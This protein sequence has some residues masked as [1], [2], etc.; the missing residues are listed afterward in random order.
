MRPM[1]TVSP[2][3][4]SGPS[5]DQLA[6]EL[7]HFAHQCVGPASAEVLSDPVVQVRLLSMIRNGTELRDAALGELHRRLATAPRVA[8]EFLAHFLSDLSRR[9]HRMRPVEYQRL[10]DTGDLVQSV[11]ADLWPDIQEVSF[12][13]RGQ[14]LSYLSKRL[15]WKSQD[16]ARALRTDRRGE[17][18]RIDWALDEIDSASSAEEPLQLVVEEEER[19]QLALA[20]FRLPDRDREL[21]MLFLRGRSIPEIAGEVHLSVEGAR[22]ALK[23]AVRKAR[24][25]I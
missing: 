17:R 22:R 8:D 11:L 7:V 9:G 14:F 12:E 5:P 3:Q 20:V 23:R 2:M 4:D 10:L 13:T 18:R 19:E 25:H 6:S 21:L 1:A 15:Q 16:R 24:R